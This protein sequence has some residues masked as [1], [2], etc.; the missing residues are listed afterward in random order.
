V[1][2]SGVIDDLTEQNPN[3][4]AILSDHRQLLPKSISGRTKRVRIL[5]AST[6]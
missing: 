2:F 6:P 1:K 3:R 4:S 5:R